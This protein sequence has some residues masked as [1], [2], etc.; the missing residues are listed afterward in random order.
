MIVDFHSHHFPDR[1]APRAIAGLCA[2]T[3]GLLW[4]IADGTLTNHL[5]HLEHD[6]V[7][8]AV[9]CQIA[10]KPT[11]FDILFKN[12]CA[13]RDGKCG[14]RAQR[15]IVPFLSVHPADPQLGEHLE[16]VAREGFKGV[17]LHPYYQDFHLDD[18]AVWPMFEKIADLGLVVECHC[19]YDIGYP[20]RSDA[21]GPKEVAVLLENVSGLTFVAAHLGGCAGHPAHATDRLLELGCYIDTSALTRNWH[22]DEEMRL[23]RSWPTDRI[24]YATDFPWTAYSESI[25]WVKSV[26]D[27][28]DWE[29]LFGGNAQRLLGL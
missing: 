6:G 1:I 10:T 19:G 23:L 12:A 2:R 16:L 13:L 7:D 4:P 27:P 5:D 22:R 11:Q 3:T 14:A 26:R 15:M 9:L 29:A 18:P 25:R 17:K 21:C 24:L 20:D 8:K 28:A